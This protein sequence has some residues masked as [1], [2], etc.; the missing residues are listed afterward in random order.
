M[1]QRFKNDI[2]AKVA[3]Y[4]LTTLTLFGFVFFAYDAQ[5]YS[6]A[7]QPP[8]PEPESVATQTELEDGVVRLEDEPIPQAASPYRRRPTGE[9]RDPL[10]LE[11]GA[12]ELQQLLD[13]TVLG[14]T[15]VLT[16]SMDE[17]ADALAQMAATTLPDPPGPEEDREDA[18]KDE[19]ADTPA[20]EENKIETEGTAADEAAVQ[21]PMKDPAIPVPDA[22]ALA[23]E[24]ERLAALGHEVPGYTYYSGTY[25][26][27]AYC[28][29]A[30]PHICGGNGVT[31]SGTVPTPGLTVAAD[32]DRLEPGTWLF[33]EGVGIRR[34]EDS[35][36]A[37][38]G[39]RLDVN[40]DT[41]QNALAWSGFGKHRVW[42]LAE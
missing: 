8:E 19:A 17:A 29:E 18:P 20:D 27:T 13:E 33:I 39:K 23:A 16:N 31:A 28:A 34:V 42:V 40:V 5:R 26:A 15:D 21:R 12:D 24:L 7:T 32:W 36:S 22:E 4:A 41:H 30:Y 9:K 11:Q 3:I 6:A 35:G 25:H 37:I 38:L 2:A 14:A 1:K 10:L